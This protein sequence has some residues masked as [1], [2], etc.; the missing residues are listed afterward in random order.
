MRSPRLFTAILAG[1]V[2]LAGVALT[3]ATA[4]ADGYYRH[5]YRYHPRPH[6]YRPPP[7]P[8]YYAPRPH[9]YRPPPPPVY[10]VPRPYYRPPPVHYGPPAVGFG[11]TI[12]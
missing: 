1:A 2:A 12:R 8:V 4:E 9:Y 5:G 7:P 10:Y 6:Y 3:P 11:I